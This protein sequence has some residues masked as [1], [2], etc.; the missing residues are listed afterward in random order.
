MTITSLDDVRERRLCW[1]E[2]KPR[3]PRRRDAPFKNRAVDREVREIGFE[4]GRFGAREYVISRNVERM[5]AGDP[6]V[7]VWWSMRKAPKE[8]PNLRVLACDQYA[9]QADNAHA[10]VLTLQAMRGL[11]R[12]GAYTIEQAVEGAKIFLPAPERPE[13]VSWRVVLGTI[14]EGLD[15]AD[16]LLVIEGRYRKQSAAAA[17]EADAD[18]KQLRLNLAI[19]AARKELRG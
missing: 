18:A 3:C 4:M 5:Y 14:P 10:I 16:A 2:H 19:E 13:Q 17:C 7:A 1:P 15:A 6:A 12:W 8:G 9:S 11:E